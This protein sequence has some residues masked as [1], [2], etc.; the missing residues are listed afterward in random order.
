MVA[1]QVKRPFEITTNLNS[2]RFSGYFDVSKI[3]MAIQTVR[4]LIEERGFQDIQLD[5][6]DCSFTHAP[7]MLTLIANCEHFKSNGIDFQLML[8]VTETLSRLFINS[9]WANLIQPDRYSP[10]DFQSSIHMAVA[11]YETPDEQHRLVNDLI[12]KFLASATYF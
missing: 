7:P 9:N 5:F 2:I 11:R 1:P 6:T 8:P 12:N 4:S 3:R 10:S